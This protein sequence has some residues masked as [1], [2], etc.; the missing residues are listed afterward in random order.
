MLVLIQKFNTDTQGI[1]L[2]EVVWKVV[3]VVIDTHIKTVV[4]F[5]DVL[6]GFS[7]GMG[8]GNSIMELKIDQELASVDQ[9][10]LFLVLLDIR[11]AYDNL[12]CRQLLRTLA[13]YGLGSKL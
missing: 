1:G 4:Q 5:H 8:T 12:D 6:H 3:E 10:P 7:A 9:D 2:M 13:G 11:K